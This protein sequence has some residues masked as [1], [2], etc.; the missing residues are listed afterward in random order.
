MTAICWLSAR[1]SSVRPHTREE[2]Q[3]SSASHSG[4]TRTPHPRDTSG[5]PSASRVPTITMTPVSAMHEVVG[6]QHL[7]PRSR[8][9][10]KFKKP[11]EDLGFGAASAAYPPGARRHVE[12]TVSQEDAMATLGTGT[13]ARARVG[14]VR[15]GRRDYR[16]VTTARETTGRHFA[17]EATEPPGGGPP[18]HARGGGRALRGARRGI[19][20][21][22]RRTRD[23]RNGWRLGVR[24]S[25]RAA[26]LQELLDA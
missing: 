13:A 25:R 26:L 17:F 20:V 19:H 24:A 6:Q 12:A 22:H 10:R 2:T 23:G 3:I 9:S 18:L 15:P 5:T 1:L 8:R 14:E 21:L 4:S 11:T 7:R 16:I